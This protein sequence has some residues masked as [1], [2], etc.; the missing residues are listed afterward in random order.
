MLIESQDLLTGRQP[1]RA[2]L[3][4]TGAP[5]PTCEGQPFDIRIGS[6][7]LIAPDD[8]EAMHVFLVLPSEDPLKSLEGLQQALDDPVEAAKQPQ[9]V[10]WP[11]LTD[12]RAADTARVL[13]NTGV[14]D[15][16]VTQ[17][18]DQKLIVYADPT[19]T[20]ADSVARAQAMVGMAGGTVSFLAAP[21]YPFDPDLLKV[22]AD[23][24]QT[25]PRSR[26]EP[27]TGSDT[28][29]SS[30]RASAATATPTAPVPSNAS[31]PAGPVTGKPPE[32]A[33]EFP[34]EPPA[35]PEKDAQPPSRTSDVIREL[36]LARRSAAPYIDEWLRSP[37]QIEDSARCHL[38]ETRRSTRRSCGRFPRTPNCSI[39]WSRGNEEHLPPSC[40]EPGTDGAC[41]TAN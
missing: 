1:P 32:T 33:S 25:S 37:E 9:A 28:V 29:T 12:E 24:L 16:V 21:Q 38:S 10:S 17:D 20:G 39:W 6:A 27:R 26:L 34:V 30:D 41:L 40:C 23:N 22:P 18:D 14:A 4:H 31:P 13:I 15:W 5:P 8:T 36:A 3:D 2:L 11:Q 7:S 19:I 35:S